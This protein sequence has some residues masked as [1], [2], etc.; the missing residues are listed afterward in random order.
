M[1]K[2]LY[3]IIAV[4]IALALVG[5]G[6]YLIYQSQQNQFLN[7]V[8][9]KLTNDELAALDSKIIELEN[10]MADQDKTLD[11][12]NEDQKSDLFKI[13]MV[14]S[15]NYRLRGRLLDARDIT[16]KAQQLKPD[17]ISTW[18]ELFVIDVARQD[19]SSAEVDLTKMLE[20][21]ANSIQAWRWYFDLTANQLQWTQAQQD[22][23]YKKALEKTTENPDI[24]ALYAGYLEKKNDLA[25]AVAAWKKAIDKNP[26]GAA[27]YQAEITRIQNRL[28]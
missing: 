19:Y 21:D 14:L 7:F 6:G 18:N 26:A 24:L 20:M 12:N 25:G 5:G 23:L 15:A 27:Q 4:V 11:K 22:E 13:E 9:P 28:K 2:K 16:L 1:N 10:S 17:N 3:I 8:D